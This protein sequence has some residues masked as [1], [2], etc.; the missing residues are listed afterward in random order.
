VR[1]EPPGSIE[2]V[3][4][5]IS[6]EPPPADNGAPPRDKIIY[7]VS[8]TTGPK[9]QPLP[10][11]FN[12]AVEAGEQIV[13]SVHRGKGVSVGDRVKVNTYTIVSKSTGKEIVNYYVR[14]AE[15]GMPKV[16]DNQNLPVYL[17]LGGTILS[18]I[19]IWLL[20]KSLPD[21][22]ERTGI[23]L[24]ALGKYTVG[25]ENSKYLPAS[26]PVVMVTDG[27]TPRELGDIHACCDRQVITLTGR[28]DRL[29]A[30]V[31]GAAGALK[32]DELVLVPETG[33]ALASLLS[34]LHQQV[35]GLAV[36]PV[37]HRQDSKTKKVKVVLHETVPATV[38]VEELQRMIRT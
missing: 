19:V 16:F 32:A 12:P 21:L 11:D 35:P 24:R 18:L 9:A 30:E 4:F 26:G 33:A 5:E 36:L 17:F 7:S 29:Q 23:W 6:F 34:Q 37:T 15:V 27:Q 3:A 31:L 20:K 22:F 13:A 10:Q 8:N 2:T 25:I 14:P 1:L 28:Q 38:G